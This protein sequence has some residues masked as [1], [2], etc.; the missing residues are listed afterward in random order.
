MFSHQK[1]VVCP[2][3]GTLLLFTGAVE[4]AGAVVVTGEPAVAEAIEGAGVSADGGAGAGADSGAGADTGA[5][6]VVGAESAIIGEAGEAWLGALS[7]CTIGIEG[8]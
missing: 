7:A 6:A 1:A 4:G 3:G 2:P 8:C 5:V